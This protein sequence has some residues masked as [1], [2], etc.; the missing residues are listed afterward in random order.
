[1]AFLFADFFV[2]LLCDLFHLV[3]LLLH[4]LD[5]LELRAGADEIVLGI[6]NAEISVAIEVVPKET[7]SAFERHELR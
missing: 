6:V 4:V 2:Y 5:E 3:H 7:H 1:M